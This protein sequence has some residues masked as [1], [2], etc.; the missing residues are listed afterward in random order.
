M[1]KFKQEMGRVYG[2]ETFKN[3]GQIVKKANQIELANRAIHF[4]QECLKSV[5]WL[6]YYKNRLVRRW[7]A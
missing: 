4:I 7:P 2:N 1:F 3:I 6:R 5:F